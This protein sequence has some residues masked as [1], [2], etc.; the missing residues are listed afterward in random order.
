MPGGSSARG[1]AG[2]QSD[3]DILVRFARTKS[4]LQMQR[5]SGGTGIPTSGY[6]CGPPST[7]SCHALTRGVDLATISVLPGSWGKKYISGLH[8]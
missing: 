5:R 3:I 6:K 2:A 7:I 8:G 4:L 1:E